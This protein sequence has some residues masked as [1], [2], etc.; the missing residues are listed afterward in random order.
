MLTSALFAAAHY[1]ALGVGFA[2]VWIRGRGLRAGDVGTIL[3]GDTLWG[4]A[5]VLWLASGLSRAFGGLEKGTDWYLAQ[6]LFWAKMGVFGLV[7]LLELWPM[8]TFVRWRIRRARG[9][10]I[11]TSPLPLLARVNAVEIALTALLPL[12]A[13]GMARGFGG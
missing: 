5:A 10:A 7:W 3:H 9:E 8:V 6:P 11:D 4:V 13:V 2:G 12:L 1:L